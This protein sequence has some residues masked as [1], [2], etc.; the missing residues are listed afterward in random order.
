MKKMRKKIRKR[1]LLDNEKEEVDNKDK[2]KTKI[3]K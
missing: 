2:S 1:F 3:T